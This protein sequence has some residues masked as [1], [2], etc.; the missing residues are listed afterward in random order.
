M[1]QI[2]DIVARRMATLRQIMALVHESVSRVECHLTADQLDAGLT[3]ER[4]VLFGDEHL[5]V[6]GPFPP[7]GKPLLLAR[8]PRC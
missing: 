3:P 1:P 4:H 7:E 8:P 6:R 5:M 2:Y